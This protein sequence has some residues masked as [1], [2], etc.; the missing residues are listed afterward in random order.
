[1]R[2][3]HCPVDWH[4]FIIGADVSYNRDWLE[5]SGGTPATYPNWNDATSVCA[6]G[7]VMRPGG[8]LNKADKELVQVYE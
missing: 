6:G 2:E 8:Y 7:L 5:T 1:M 3:V 4:R